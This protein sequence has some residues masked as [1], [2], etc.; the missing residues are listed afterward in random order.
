MAGEIGV[1]ARAGWGRYRGAVGYDGRARVGHPPGAGRQ[2]FRWTAGASQGVDDNQELAISPNNP[3][4][5]YLVGSS[6]LQRSS[7][8][9][10]TFAVVL[11]SVT[12]IYSGAVAMDPRNPATVYVVANVNPSNIPPL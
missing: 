9:G 12:S 10:R 4:I 11:P 7:D 5:L 8:G 2:R 3:S 1:I 6:G